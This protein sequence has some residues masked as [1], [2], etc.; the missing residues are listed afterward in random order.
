MEVMT[1]RVREKKTTGRLAG[2]GV[3][4]GISFATGPPDGIVLHHNL[5]PRPVVNNLRDSFRILAVDRPRG[6]VR[7]LDGVSIASPGVAFQMFNAAFLSAPVETQTEL[8]S[9]L[10]TARNH[11]ASRSLPWSFWF[12]ESWLAEDVRRRLTRGCEEAGLR[13]ASEMPGMV[14][15]RLDPTRRRL[16]ELE[17]RKVARGETLEHFRQIGA[18]CFHVPP[19]WF[20]EVFDG[21]PARSQFVCWVGY[22]EGTPV[23]TAASVVSNGAIGIYNVATTSAHRGH[24]YGETMTRQAIGEEMARHGAGLPVVLQSTSHGLPLYDR[25]GFRSVTRIVVFNSR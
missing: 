2:D 20:S 15:E 23:A 6:D 5:R 18:E 16:P 12:C 25:M 19:E 3:R 7:E 8:A 9:R 21:N 11:F 17:I 4:I 10:G 13:I 24:G 22:R 1:A 14:A